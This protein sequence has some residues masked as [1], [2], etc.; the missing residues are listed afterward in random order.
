MKSTW[1][2]FWDLQCPFSRKSWQIL[3]SVRQ[4]Y[5]HDY[6]FTIHLTSLLFHKQAFTGQAAACLIGKYKGSEARLAF[7]DTCFEHQDK[8]MKDAVG[9]AC[10]SEIGAIFA[11]LAK[12]AGIFDDA[13]FTEDMFMSKVSNWEEAEKPAWEEHKQA[14]SYGVFGAPKHVIN[15]ELITDAESG[16]GVEEW[17][18]KLSSKKTRLSE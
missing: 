11:N 13:D 14:L 16:W 17:E 7:I 2:V 15:G 6:E 18:A 10:P 1:K 12:E 9:D 3:P 5:E 8:Y 4:K